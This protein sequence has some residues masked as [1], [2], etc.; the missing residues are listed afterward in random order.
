MA[1]DR[2]DIERVRQATNLVELIE[3]VTTVKKSG[4]SLMAVCPF[5]QEKSASMS[6]DAGRGLYNCFGCGEGGDVFSFLQ[7]FQGLTFAEALEMLATRAGIVLERDPKA[8]KREGER[9]ET[10][11]VIRAAG[12]FYQ[13]SLKDSPDAGHARAYVRG[14]GYGVEVIDQFE[15]GYSPEEWDGLTKYLRG[16]GF[17]DRQMEAAGVSKRGRGGKLYDHFRGRLMFPIRNVRGEMVGFGGRLLRGEGAKYIN[18]P[19]TRLYKKAELLYGLDRARSEISRVGFAVVVEGYTDVI[20]LHLAGYPVAVATCGTAL[21]E[22]HFDLLRRF[23]ERIVLAF[24]A[25]QA[26]AGAAIRGDELR[27]PGALGLDLRV[28][29]MPEGRDPAELV[30]EGNVELLRKAVDESEPIMQFRVARALEQ[31]DLSEP[32]ARARAIR[33]VVPLIARQPD[34][35]AR[36]EYARMVAR[37]TGTELEPILGEIETAARGTQP[38]RPQTA[39]GPPVLRGTELAERELL[40]HLLAGTAP[41]DLVRPELFRAPGAQEAARWLLEASVSLSTGTPVHLIGIDDP[42][43]EAM[44]RRLAVVNDP[45]A[46]A[47][48]VVRRL[49]RRL[50]DERIGA[51]KRRL[52]ALDP[53]ADA[54]EYSATFKELIALE[55]TKRQNTEDGE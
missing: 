39:A 24:D 37:R 36:R 23:S 6:I 19:E 5:H 38:R 11:D 47:D 18:T 17:K 54:Q 33:Q 34:A 15:I 53:D 8:T 48:D 41:L 26:G 22:E 51:L 43:V 40:R 14:R 20:A 29:V 30:E 32:E 28:A 25:D 16:R 12:E 27:L 31:H 9:R 2:D 49:E 7:E 4:R 55:R 46:P 42:N 35:L 52:E 1:A 13:K 10:I 44:L 21:G 3:S 45:L 50:T